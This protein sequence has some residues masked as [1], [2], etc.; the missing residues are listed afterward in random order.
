MPSVIRKLNPDITDEDV[1]KMIPE[2]LKLLYKLVMPINRANK[3]MTYQKMVELKTVPQ[4]YK[5]KYPQL[6]EDDAKA[7]WDKIKALQPE[8]KIVE[9]IPLRDMHL[10][11][12]WQQQLI[13]RIVEYNVHKKKVSD[14][15]ADA[16]WEV[17]SESETMTD[18]QKKLAKEKHAKALD[19]FWAKE[20][21]TGLL[22]ITKSR[23]LKKKWAKEAKEAENEKAK[24]AK[25]E[26]EKAESEKSDE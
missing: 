18:E 12:N 24:K 9:E 25:V 10:K 11:G 4:D 26:N 19:K 1:D 21:A 5:S 16:S 20:D 22:A 13:A 23:E 3:V 14:A 8:C 15:E 17:E 7:I 6:T 2:A